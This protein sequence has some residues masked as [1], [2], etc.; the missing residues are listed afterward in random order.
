MDLIETSWKRYFRTDESAVMKS[1]QLLLT[2]FKCGPGGAGLDHVTRLAQIRSTFT[3]EV[4]IRELDEILNKSSTDV[5]Y[6]IGADQS[7]FV[8]ISYFSA[9]NNIQQNIYLVVS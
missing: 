6:A 3:A 2:R 7:N 8:D 9:R 5:T 4:E 1:L